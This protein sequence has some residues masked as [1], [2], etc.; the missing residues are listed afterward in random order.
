[1]V[2]ASRALGKSGFDSTEP[3]MLLGNNRGRPE[4]G[5]SYRGQLLLDYR[6]ASIAPE[7]MKRTDFLVGGIIS[8]QIKC[9]RRYLQSQLPRGTGELSKV[10]L[11]SETG[12]S[13]VVAEE[14]DDM[15][16]LVTVPLPRRT[17]LKHVG[18]PD[19]TEVNS[20]EVFTAVWLATEDEPADTIHADLMGSLKKKTDVSVMEVAKLVWPIAATLLLALGAHL[21]VMWKSAAVSR[22][23]ARVEQLQ[24]KRIEY[25]RLQQELGKL[26]RRMAA[27]KS[28]ESALQP[29]DWNNVVKFAGRALPQGTWLR[30]IEIVDGQMVALSGSSFTDEAIYEYVEKL[31]DS[32]LFSRVTLDGTRSTRTATGPAFEFDVSTQAFLTIENEKAVANRTPPVRL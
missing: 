1:L 13:P 14:L 32:K 21:S 18:L 30:T 20:W 9:V 28:V 19:T 27:V 24:P 11:P 10:C 3:V 15:H 17:L 29:S 23:D 5:V 4:L 12:L 6:P 22:V 7:F 2:A 26:D 8:K 25:T 16:S 31:R